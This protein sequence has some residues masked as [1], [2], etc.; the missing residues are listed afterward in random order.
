MDDRFLPHNFHWQS[1]KQFI[2]FDPQLRKLSK[3]FY[4]HTP[5]LLQKI[6]VNI[7]GIYTLG[8]GRQIGKT[9]LLKQWM[10][11][12]IEKNI[13]P[14]S[15]FFL[16][17]EVIYDHL[18]LIQI[19]SQYLEQIPTSSSSM[20]YIIVDEITYIKNWDQGV[21][22][23]ADTGILENVQLVLT[24]SDLIFIQEARMRF[25]GRRG[26]S[27][28][29]DFH[30]YP[31]SF[32]EFVNLKLNTTEEPAIDVLFQEFENYLSHGGF[33]T[34]INDQ[35]KNDKISSIAC[36]YSSSEPSVMV[37]ILFVP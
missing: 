34:A 20:I 31:L 25:P 3:Q 17:G 32:F 22:Y 14:K 13:N 26:S 27:D 33:L 30:L 15:I 36:S 19:I 16:T 11:L 28:V 35:A 5:S 29:V 23:L 18:S 10:R 12:L 2:D 4:V 9:T 21:K 6:P 24:G 1:I 37:I 7:S 8:G